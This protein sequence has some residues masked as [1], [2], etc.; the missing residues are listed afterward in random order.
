M[1][2]S[3]P[4]YFL[5]L[6]IHVFHVQDLIVV[7]HPGAAAVSAVAEPLGIVAVSAAAVP[8]AVPAVAAGIAAAGPPG[9]AAAIVVVSRS[10]ERS[11]LPL[12]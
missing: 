10:H 12:I 7:V 1:T 9:F 5:P 11:V 6:L 4:L 3:I 2:A 8:A